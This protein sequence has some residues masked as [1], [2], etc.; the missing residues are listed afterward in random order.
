MALRKGRCYRNVTRAYTR[1]SK[2][3]TKAFIKVIPPT[4]ITK[5][6]L[7]NTKKQFEKEVNL[8][9]K[10]KIQIR[11]NALESARM[12]VNRRLNTALGNNYHFRLRVYPH[13]VLREN[14]AITG[15]GA[16]R[17]SSG[18]SQSFGV[19]IGLAA[20]LKPNQPIITIY[21]DAKDVNV[22]KEILKYA[23]HRLPCKC[24]II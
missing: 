5:F 19:P 14:K 1:K 6:D 10:E 8:V 11:D 9:S 2:F 12:V 18:M 21:V 7:G 15:A 16:D 23:T 17:I 4:K 24:A 22:A 13:H 20:Q 3:R